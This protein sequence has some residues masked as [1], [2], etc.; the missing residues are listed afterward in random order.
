MSEKQVSDLIFIILLGNALCAK[1]HVFKHSCG[2][3]TCPLVINN[4]PRDFNKPDS[5]S[6]QAGTDVY[7]SGPKLTLWLKLPTR[8]RCGHTIASLFGIAPDKAFLAA[9]VTNGTGGLLHHH[10]TLAGHHESTTRFVSVELALHC[11]SFPLGSILPKVSGLSSVLTGTADIFRS[12]GRNCFFRNA[13]FRV[14]KNP[15]LL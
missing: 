7:P 3:C 4:L 12:R 13:G 14:C 8:K 9:T 2:R 5:V 15:V 11:C 6:R 10:F 1:K